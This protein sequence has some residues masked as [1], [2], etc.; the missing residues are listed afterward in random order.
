MILTPMTALAFHRRNL[1]LLALSLL[2]TLAVWWLLHHPAMNRTVAVPT[3]HFLIVSTVSVIALALAAM[4]TVASLQIQQYRVL[5]LG[6]GFMSMA[7]LFAVH[8][9]STPGI[10]SSLEPAA[11]AGGPANAGV[12][13]SSYGSAGYGS[14]GSYGGYGGDAAAPARS[15][16]QAAA[17]PVASAYGGGYAEHDHADHALSVVGLSAFLSLL[18]PALL[19]TVSFTRFGTPLGWRIPFRP[20]ALV[21]SVTVALALYAV[22]ALARASLFWDNPLLREPWSSAVTWSSGLLF[23]ACALCQYRVYRITR[24]PL[25]GA[26]ILSFLFLAQAGIS[27]MTAPLWTLAWWAYHVLMLAAVGI[28]LATLLFE[29]RRGQPV[30]RVLE[31][32]MELQV[33]VGIELEHVEEIALLAAATEAKDPDTKGHTV[34]VAEVAVAIG[35][36]MGLSYERLRTLA[37]SGLLHDVGKI[38]IPDA[39][40]LK[41]GPLDDAEWEIMKQHPS[42]GLD[43]LQKLGTLQREA[44][45]LIAHHER[46]NGQGYPRGLVGEEIPLEARIISV[47]D[48]FDALVSDRPYRRGLPRSQ[49]LD[50]LQ[51]ES[52]THLYPPAV[53]AFMRIFDKGMLAQLVDGIY[54]RS[55]PAA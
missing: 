41:P 28:S 18:V 54:R 14:Y 42:L 39:V 15:P 5:F 30:R 35:R 53:S 34:R 22:L 40:L 26:L 8:A 29:D 3:Q 20:A 48:T 4:V 51:S 6:L 50:I 44:E 21:L 25:Q 12:A 17:A 9:L 52:G 46:W 16:R 55:D 23:V 33:E 45:I 2:P 13:A 37:R 19:F 11:A 1:A 27:M 49:A 10:F 47:A 7:G 36:E 31:G 43:I 24:L 38:M 32:A